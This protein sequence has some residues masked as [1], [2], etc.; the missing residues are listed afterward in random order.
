MEGVLSHSSLHTVCEPPA[1]E[2]W[3]T[4]TTLRQGYAKVLEEIF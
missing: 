3:A 2:E 4:T 1:A